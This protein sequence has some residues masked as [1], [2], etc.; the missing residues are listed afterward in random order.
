MESF[1][2][3]SI[4]FLKNKP[5]RESRTV[6]LKESDQ[7]EPLARAVCAF[8]NARRK[9][10]I[11]VGVRDDGTLLGVARR[12]RE[13]PSE[14]AY[15]NAVREGMVALLVPQPRLL[16]RVVRRDGVPLLK[17]VIPRRAPYRTLIRYGSETLIREGRHTRSMTELEIA[18]HRQ[19]AGWWRAGTVLLSVA[20]LAFMVVLGTVF[21]HF[22]YTY[23]AM[24]QQG[25]PPFYILD[26]AFSPALSADNR[27]IFFNLATLDNPKWDIWKID[28]QTGAMQQ[29]TNL[30]GYEERPSQSHDGEWLYFDWQPE[31]QSV[32]LMRQNLITG[33]LQTLLNDPNY[34]FKQPIPFADGERFLFIAYQDYQPARIGIGRIGQTTWQP[35]TPNTLDCIMPTLAQDD[36]A[37]AAVCQDWNNGNS[38]NEWGILLIPLDT[39]EP[40]CLPLSL[41]QRNEHIA[42]T[43]KDEIAFSYQDGFLLNLYAINLKTYKIRTLSSFYD[44]DVSSSPSGDRIVFI[45]TL[46]D[47]NLNFYTM[48]AQPE[49]TLEDSPFYWLYPHWNRY[50]LGGTVNAAGYIKADLPENASGPAIVGCPLPVP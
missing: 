9:A 20:V 11:W 1:F 6:E 12:V 27:F 46:R 18:Q 32:R 39:L 5:L 33:E 2:S 30:P 28:A 16:V 36:Y 17:I 49:R 43:A 50:I 13:Y 7:P 26:K 45:S 47:L 34:S 44:I 31:Y 38:K 8:A 19:R 15:A 10:T 37:I 29:I 42:F 4:H 22:W 40:A 21:V 23:A 24:Q 25:I 41:D 35:L 48:P 14:A 3:T